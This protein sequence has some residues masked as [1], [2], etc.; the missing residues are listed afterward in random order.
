M[1]IVANGQS[2]GNRA[3]PRLVLNGVALSVADVSRF[4]GKFAQR[5]YQCWP[6]N[7]TKDP[8]GYGLFKAAGKMHRAHRVA[9]AL[10][11]RRFIPDGLLVCHR[12]DNPI[13]VSPFHLF[14]GTSA[15]NTA[16]MIQKGR[17][18]RTFCDPLKFN[19]GA[20]RAANLKMVGSLHPLA[21]LTEAVVSQI[22]S[23]L[24]S[25]ESGVTVARRFGCSVHT[26]SNIKRGIQWRHV[27]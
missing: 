20:W 17:R 22:K 15:D 8:H 13:C 18:K 27:A 11:R 10:F 2:E 14:L 3:G 26:V 21:K 7:G 23:A 25:G 12:C 5:P 6:W 1:D 24:Q 4:L 19:I 9:W 16:D